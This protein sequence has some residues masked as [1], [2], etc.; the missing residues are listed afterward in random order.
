[1]AEAPAPSATE[2]P[3]APIGAVEGR[4]DIVSV[5]Q[6][7]FNQYVDQEL[8]APES[9][10]SSEDAEAE[11]AVAED[12]AAKDAPAAKDTPA[13]D[14]GPKEG[15]LDGANVFFRGKWVKKHDFNYRVHI[16]TE[17]AKAALKTEMEATQKTAREAQ[18]A[19]DKAARERDELRAKYEPAPTTEIG[20]E[21]NPQNYTDM[22]KFTADLK[23]WATKNARAEDARLRQD[24][25]IKSE[26]E[27]TAKRWK[28]A[29]AAITAEIPDYADRLAKAP[30]LN[31]PVSPEL[32]EAIIDSDVGVKLRL[33]LAENPEIVRDLLKMP[34]GRMLKQVG[35]LEVELGKPAD[36]APAAAASTLGQVQISK[37]PEP[38]KP[39]RGGS[40]PNS[41]GVYIDA[42]GNWT[43]TP[44]QFKAARLAG[45]IK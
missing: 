38:I 18:E 12:D 14:A 8:G 24:A 28:D 13:A 2:Q 39:L 26:Q 43:G 10:V 32:T 35:K 9:A 30:G 44:E 37:A 27:Q 5:T 25:Q 1:M 7:N 33:H 29:E 31:I 34:V 45:K 21:P 17:E 20:P 42:N 40:T 15:D 3:A 11:A 23:E 22:A 6:E 19:L 4:P 16:K 36:S 41:T